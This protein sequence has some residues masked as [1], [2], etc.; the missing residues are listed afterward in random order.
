MRQQASSRE[1][2]ADQ[3]PDAWI[4]QLAVV[5]DPP[6]AAT[7]VATLE[8]SGVTDLVLIPTGDDPRTRLVELSRV[9]PYVRRG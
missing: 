6:A 7:R 3:L 9:L 2:F 5:G 1:E 8:N 4:E